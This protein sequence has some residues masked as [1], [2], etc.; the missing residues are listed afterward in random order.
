[1]KIPKAILFAISIIS[2][3]TTTV[4]ASE[5]S[6]QKDLGKETTDIL[7]PLSDVCDINFEYDILVMEGKIAEDRKINNLLTIK[8]VLAIPLN[9]DWNLVTRSTLPFPVSENFQSNGSW[10]CDSGFGD[11]KLTQMITPDNG[12]GPI[13]ILGA[14]WSW[15]FPTAS[16]KTLGQGKYQLGPAFAVGRITDK[17]QVAVVVQQ[18]WSVGGDNE[19]EDAS[20]LNIEY[21][22]QW[23]VTPTFTIGM[24]PIIT[25]D[26][27][28]D[29]SNRWTVPIGLGCSKTIQIGNIPVNFSIE[30]DYSVIRPKDFG[31]E[32]DI[33]FTIT[34]SFPNPFKQN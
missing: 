21:W 19:R 2:V 11:M 33:N 31:E 27:R 26:W 10:N 8:P 12:I 22:L 1:M 29:L 13:N 3:L 7:N 5:T 20:S 9:K 17:Y 6:Q 32:W 18:W 25:A 15:I 34:P 24:N 16:D 28:Q 4:S 14:G 30:A 23:R